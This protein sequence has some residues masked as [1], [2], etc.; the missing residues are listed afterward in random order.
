MR[1][2]LLF[3]FVFSLFA[4]CLSDL[5]PKGKVEGKVR[6]PSIELLKVAKAHGYQSWRKSNSFKCTIED[7]FFGVIG[8][9]ASPF[10]ESAVE[11]EVGF[12]R[13]KG[14]GQI[15]IVSGKDSATIWRYQ[16]GK[17]YVDQN[18][19]MSRVPVEDEIIKFWI[20]TY[21]YFLEFPFRILEADALES[22]GTEKIGDQRYSKILAS[23][24]TVEPQEDIDQYLIYI[25]DNQQV[26]WI[27]YTIR[28]QYKFLK[29]RAVYHGY[30]QVDGVVV[31]E[32]IEIFSS[33]TGKRRALHQMKISNVEF[34]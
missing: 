11:L 34:R 15:K 29:G 32:R 8:K 13:G 3:I 25:D 30:H 26:A 18:G 24:K 31:P 5:R 7:S 2:V 9:R 12:L 14:E 4:S 27:D 17:S 20:P 23:W 19:E 16:G 21:A 28:D 1:E 6:S 22:L 10:K 33:L